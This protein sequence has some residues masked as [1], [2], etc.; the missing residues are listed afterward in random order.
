M[1]ATCVHKGPRGRCVRSVS[2]RE[3]AVSRRGQAQSRAGAE[4]ARMQGAGTAVLRPRGQGSV[5]G[6][7]C[8]SVF[9]AGMGAQPHL[10]WA[11]LAYA[12]EREQNEPL[13]GKGLRR[14]A[15]WRPLPWELPQRLKAEGRGRGRSG[16]RG[17]AAAGAQEGN[18]RDLLKVGG[19][20]QHTLGEDPG[21]VLESCGEVSQPQA[22][23]VSSYS[24]RRTAVF[25]PGLV[26]S[27]L[28]PARL[29]V[30]RALQPL[31]FLYRP[32]GLRAKAPG[33]SLLG[34]RAGGH[35]WGPTVEAFA[36]LASPP[37]HSS[38]ISAPSGVTLSAVPTLRFCH[39][40]ARLEPPGF[41]LCRSTAQAHQSEDTPFLLAR[42]AWGRGQSLRLSPGV[43]TGDS[44]Q[45]GR[46]RRGPAHAQTGAINTRASCSVI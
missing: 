4:R 14:E 43:T 44:R 11:V 17:L 41:P 45:R 13:V 46:P 6:R 29:R 32:L 35:P 3:S 38:P 10:D 36:S 1:P 22:S 27:L 15:T 24:P 5:A 16:G 31:A 37:V 26:A 12:C 34:W 7:R 8:R 23:V 18:G 33:A 19:L 2:G 20:H 9:L 25:T 30:Q 21:M 42:R 28:T 39:P 40:R